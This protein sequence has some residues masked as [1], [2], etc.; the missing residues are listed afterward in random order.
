MSVRKFPEPNS[1]RPASTTSIRRRHFLKSASV[2]MAAASLPPIYL[3]RTGGVAQAQ[4]GG[5]FRGP[6]CFFSKH[7]A[8]VEPR[9]MAESLRQV[10]FTGVDLTV[11]EGG[12]VAPERAAE[13]LPKVF[14]AIREASLE[15]PMIT[16]GLTSATHETARPI[17]SAAGKLS[18]PFFKPGYYR[19][20]FDDVR[21]ELRMAGVE[22]RGLME[23]GK[24][25][26][27][28]LGY[29][30]H[31]SYLGAHVWDAATVIDQL[32]P[33]WAGYYFDIRHATVEGGEGGWKIATHLVAPR[34]LMIAVKDFYWEKT[35]KGWNVKD[36]PLGEGMVDWKTYFSILAKS[37]FQGPISFHFEYEVGGL[38]S[39]AKDDNMLA[40]A[41]R[42]LDFLK[43]RLKEAY[44][45]P[46]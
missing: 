15:V 37:G 21:A 30:N 43:A 19:Y 18:I 13:Q 7:L 34:L 42:D 25:F 31:S 27:V 8:G 26:G 14:A 28:R 45:V 39:S 11:R 24:E 22:L 32:D 16:T 20:K 44:V 40:A 29:H 2:A 6:L 41:K 36:C 35:V 3:S 9:R 46:A 10:G 4:G 33:K 38:T 1:F 17:L 12:H 23:L 5:G